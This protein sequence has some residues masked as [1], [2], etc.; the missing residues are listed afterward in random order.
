MSFEVNSVGEK[1]NFDFV[2]TIRCISMVGIVF[3][4]SVVFDHFH[5]ESLYTSLFQA[6]VM[7]FFKFAT[8]TFFL[9]AG[10]LINYKFTE[11]SALQYINNRLK[12][13]IKP[14]AIWLHV[15]IALDIAN[16]LV[17]YFKY[18]RERPLPSL[19]HFLM[20]EY[21]D[22][23]FM[24][25]FWF[26][27]NFLICIAI[28]LMFKKYLYKVWFGVILLAI[29]L[30]YSVNLYYSWIPTM[31]TTALFGFIFYLWLG[32]YINRYY[33]QISKLIHR[34]DLF[35][36]ILF[37]SI[38]FL[39]ADFEI[40]H[41]QNSFVD[42]AYNTLRISNI[43]Y[44]LFFFAM[45]LKIGSVR[46]INTL[47]EPRNTTFG[48]YLI[49]TLIILHALKLI[50]GPLHIQ[51]ASLTLAEAMAYSMVRFILA[52]GISYVLTRILIRTRIKWIIGA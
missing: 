47:L 26:I 6:S 22:I 40:I 27:L 37:V 41:L 4:H 46:W 14:W 30:F 21:F 50:F 43:I 51:L 2:D 8:I 12:K 19:M 11:Y 7:Q 5:Y 49:H 52:Y 44:S 29:S 15:L 33:E 25:S 20:T 24:T 45:L 48:I 10:F 28:L 42:D 9:I 32:A 36:F 13:T 1:R 38:S 16:V 34:T 39:L 35:W 31:H 18:K 23:V 3:E 17:I